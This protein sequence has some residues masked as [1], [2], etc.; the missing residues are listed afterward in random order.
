VNSSLLAGSGVFRLLALITVFGFILLSVEFAF[1]SVSTLVL[2]GKKAIP[3]FFD[4]VGESSGVSDF[5]VACIVL[6]RRD[7]VGISRLRVISR[8]WGRHCDYFIPITTESD[9]HAG[10]IGLMRTKSPYV[11][12]EFSMFGADAPL[13]ID[14]DPDKMPLMYEA[15][16]YSMEHYG[17]NASWFV[18]ADDSTFFRPEALRDFVSKTSLQKGPRYLGGIQQSERITY[19]PTRSSIVLNRSAIK[20]LL[21]AFSQPVCTF[22]SQYF[23]EAQSDIA[24]GKCFQALSVKPE[25]TVD[26]TGNSRFIQNPLEIMFEFSEDDELTRLTKKQGEGLKGCCSFDFVAVGGLNGTLLEMYSYVFNTVQIASDN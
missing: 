20:L 13:E 18:L 26:D 9:L 6:A 15:L 14:S 16:R 21:E 4:S 17:S 12:Y 3:T 25:I 1:S 11:Q 2:T 24:I 7:N 8:T 19:V 23:A 5:S 22:G 10:E